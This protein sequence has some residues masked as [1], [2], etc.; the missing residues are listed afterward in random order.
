MSVKNGINGWAG[1]V[2][3]VN[4]TTGAITTEDTLPKYKPFIGGMGLG[5]K[6]IW[7]E[8][9]LDSDP[10]GPA[11]KA[12]FAVGPLTASGVPCSGRTNISFLSCWSKGQS[13]LDAHMGGHFA[14]A[15]KYSGYDAV[16]VEGQSDKPVYIK[17]DDENVTLE[18]ASH[19]WGKGTFET[20]ATLS[21]ECGP[22]FD[23]ASIG[24]AG[25]NLVPMS[26][27]ITS[28]GNSGG[29][30]IGALLGSKK[31]KAIVARGTGAVKIARPMEV[32]LL[33]NYM[34]K[35][36]V[37][38]NNNHN[39]PS[40]PQ[41]WSEYS[42][43]PRNRWQGGP[44]VTWDK[45]PSGP[46][47][48]GEQPSG[49]INVAALRCNKGVFDFGEVAEKYTVKQ[50]GCSSC[51]VRCY[52]EYEMDPLAD[53]DLPTHV[54]NTCMPIISGKSIYPEGT[55]DFVDEGDAGMILGGA[56]SRA[57]D[58]YGVWCNYGNLYSDFSRT[59]KD[60]ILREHMTDE[61]WN[62]V[63]WDLM[64]DG[65][66]RWCF[67]FFRLIAEGKGAW[68]DIGK[69]TYHLYA[70]WGLDDASKNSAGKNYYDEVLD[71]N[72]NVTYNG[73]PKH[74]SSED[75]W[76]S[77]LLFNAMYNRDCMI[78]HLTNFCRSGSPYGEVI[79][80]VLEGFFGEG[81]VDAPKAYTPI[82]E[83]KVKLAKWAFNGKQWHD[84][85]TLC[86]WMYPMTLSTSKKRGYAGDLDL[87]AK[88]MS[89]VVGEEYTRE[90]LEFETER[91]SNLLR[92]MTAVSFKLNLGSTNLRQDHD[93]I[94]AW[95]FDK[96]PDFEAFEEGTVKMDRDDMKKAFDMFYEAMGWDVETGIPTRETLEKFDLKDCADKLAE[97]GLIK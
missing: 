96:E 22:E 64:K 89:A 94:P 85:A 26:T 83:N 31:V 41:S 30:G 39:V 3:R 15:L 92:V 76:Q 19:V 35:D 10:L 4:L 25:E 57:Q 29:A 88:Y 46:I 86:N 12:V 51:P 9:P 95:V 72:T 87:D 58:D 20:N 81:C 47:D 79:K 56:M 63:N 90:S 69:G 16:I 36:L 67:E 55:H 6:V 23:V 8:V 82:N 61:E 53:Y 27:L 14:H 78:H 80:P 73:Y 44:G 34:I 49:I 50:G 59:Y 75:A 37:G 66:P 62:A 60:G 54:S 2:L 71:N 65:D 45:A 21:K 11:A 18:D 42:A 70:A 17:I 7:D 97:L 38:G 93:A 28:F 24:L 48:T 33:S 1:S 91:I 52:T 74:H 32:R 43:V 68:G 77:G 40:V 13:I 84:S 5:Y